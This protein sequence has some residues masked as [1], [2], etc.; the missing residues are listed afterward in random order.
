MS[1]NF[2]N[3]Y[4]FR[5]GVDRTFNLG[6]GNYDNNLYTTQYGYQTTFSALGGMKYKTNRLN[7]NFNTFLIKATESK[8]QDQ[9]GYTNSLANKTNN[10][11]KRKRD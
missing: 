3:K 5:E 10:L 9:L 11:I 8:I 4:S 6:Q 2:E 7:L 1:F